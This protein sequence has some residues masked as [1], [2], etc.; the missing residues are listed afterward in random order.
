MYSWPAN[1]PLA[2]KLPDGEKATEY[3]ES[4]CREKTRIQEPSCT[5]HN[6]TDPSKEAVAKIRCFVGFWEPGPVGLLC[7]RIKT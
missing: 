6:R 2:K 4:R 3:T 1:E 5:F 7:D